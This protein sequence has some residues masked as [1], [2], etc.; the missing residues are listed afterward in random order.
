[1]CAAVVKRI[2]G[3]KF[4]AQKLKPHAKMACH[5]FQIVNSKKTAAIKAQK[6]EI[7]GLLAEGKVEKARIRVEHLIRLDWTIE[8]NEI[9]AIMCELVHERVTY[10]A[11]SP[12]CPSDM[13]EAICTL[14][15][16]ANRAECP[17]LIEI[18]KQFHC[19]FG[20]E[21]METALQNEARCVNE[22]VLQ[23]L[24]VQPPSAHHVQRYLVNI[25]KEAGVD[26][27]PEEAPAPD[28]LT[29]FSVPV[30]PGSEYAEI[31]AD[32]GVAPVIPVAASAV[33]SPAATPVPA[34][35]VSLSIPTT[36]D[37][38]APQPP[39]DLL[40]VPATVLGVVP[41]PA[42]EDERPPPPPSEK[43]AIASGPP[44]IP[45]AADATPVD[46]TPAHAAPLEADVTP[47]DATPADAAP[48]PPTETLPPSPDERLPPP[49]EA[50]HNPAAPDPAAPEVASGGN[51]EYDALQARFAQLRR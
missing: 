49:P 23:R 29:G 38:P 20:D 34:S 25:A 6:R 22:R 8:A 12:H 17:E 33:E 50:T 36:V 39:D 45:L 47:M 9:L 31:Y 4:S 27:Q 11:A 1:M 37:V 18:A 32:T 19:K 26:W 16:A 35:A 21:F 2:F 10:L 13:H 7:A 48:A 14:I 44:V 51:P 24:A 43:P 41:P 15:W 30:A 42:G 40:S 28:L 3:P 46:A 5:R